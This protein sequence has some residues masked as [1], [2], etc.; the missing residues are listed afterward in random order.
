MPVSRTGNWI[1]TVSCGFT[2]GSDGFVTG[3][4]GKLDANRL[5]FWLVGFGHLVLE[6]LIKNRRL[7]TTQSWN[8]GKCDSRQASRS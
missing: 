8:L 6:K 7:V 5:F 4:C 1:R 2:P 3:G